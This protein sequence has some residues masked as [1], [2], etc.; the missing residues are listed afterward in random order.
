[1][2]PADIFPGLRC[3]DHGTGPVP[4]CP[5][6]EAHGVPHLMIRTRAGLRTYEAT[7][8]GWCGPYPARWL[9]VSLE[10]WV[11]QA[12]E[13]TPPP[14]HT[15]HR[16][17]RVGVDLWTTRCGGEEKPLSPEPTCPKCLEIGP[18]D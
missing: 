11:V 16:G 12:M 6:H 18:N 13:D 1:M 3:L 5:P 2:D 10:W 9:A 14:E 7:G 15:H 17:L 4:P 8:G